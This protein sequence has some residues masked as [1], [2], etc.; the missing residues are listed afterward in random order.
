MEDIFV[1]ECPEC[2]FK[3]TVMFED[4][5]IVDE[6]EINIE[7]PKLKGTEKEEAEATIIRQHFL[8]EVNEYLHKCDLREYRRI[9]C[10]FAYVLRNKIY[11]KWYIK[12][13]HMHFKDIVNLNFDKYLESF[14]ISTLI[15][16]EVIDE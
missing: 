14:A 16:I 7:L 1:S 8:D 2:S 6:H 12:N 11:A 9:S 4:G 15:K 13:K 5:Y 3:H 10:A